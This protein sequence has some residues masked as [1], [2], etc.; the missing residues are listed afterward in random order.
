MG[1]EFLFVPENYFFIAGIY[2]LI[3]ITGGVAL[4]NFF[5][6]LMTIVVGAFCSVL[7]VLIGN[8]IPTMLLGSAIAEWGTISALIINVGIFCV[9]MKLLF[10]LK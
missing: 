4:K 9:S 7:I 3:A 1:L 2:G 10:F 5:T 6:T 8:V